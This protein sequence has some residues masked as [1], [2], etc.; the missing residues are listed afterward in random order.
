VVRLKTQVKRTIT[1]RVFSP[2]AG[3]WTKLPAPNDVPNIAEEVNFKFWAEGI[4]NEVFQ[5]Y[6]DNP[7]ATTPTS[8]KWFLNS[9]TGLA[10]DATALKGF[11]ISPNPASSQIRLNGYAGIYDLSIHTLQGVNVFNKKAMIGEQLLDVS[12]LTSGIYTAT[13][14]TA[15][16][17]KKKTKF[18]IQ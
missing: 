3:G 7:N 16:G 6:Y 2:L 17:T 5:I 11:V 8:V 15:N 13:I 1:V 12:S 9:A 10:D 4:G 18:V 14:E